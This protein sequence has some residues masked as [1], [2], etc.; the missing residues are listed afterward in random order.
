MK[1]LHALRYS[2]EGLSI[3]TLELD[4]FVVFVCCLLF[5]SLEVE[6]LKQKHAAVDLDAAASD[7]LSSELQSF[8]SLVQLLRTLVTLPDQG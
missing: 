3:G 2:K 6:K 5:A 1:N 4:G 8:R 7:V